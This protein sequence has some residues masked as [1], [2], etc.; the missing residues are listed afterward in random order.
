MAGKTM[1]TTLFAATLLPGLPTLAAGGPPPP[2]CTIKLDST[3]VLVAPPGW[4]F[5][6]CAAAERDQEPIFRLEPVAPRSDPPAAPEFRGLRMYGGPAGRGTVEAALATD[7]EFY[8]TEFAPKDG[9]GLRT[10]DRRDVR[11]LQFTHRVEPFT[12]LVHG[13]FRVGPGVFWLA[14]ECDREEECADNY[15][16][17]EYLV[18]ATRVSRPNEFNGR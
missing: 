14:Y 15:S 7:R 11:V 10:G 3:Y 16:A 6:E 9:D 2:T 8:S 13:F 1:R 17:F 5:L 18:A 12:W 4:Q